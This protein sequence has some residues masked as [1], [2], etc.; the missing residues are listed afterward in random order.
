MPPFVEASLA[1]E[2]GAPT[3]PV[4]TDFGFHVIRV[5]PLDEVRAEL[6]A[7]FFSTEFAITLTIE[8][9]DVSI[10]PRY[11][12]IEAGVVVPLA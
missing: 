9:L 11:G 8:E 10:A 7:L 4:A 5:R 1:A 12:T 3:E 6:D 2:I